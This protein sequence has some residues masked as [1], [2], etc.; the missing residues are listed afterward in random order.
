MSIASLD[1]TYCEKGVSFQLQQQKLQHQKQ[2][3]KLSAAH[4]TKVRSSF[5]PGP[6]GWQDPNE[7]FPK[8]LRL[9]KPLFVKWS[10]YMSI[11]QKAFEPPPPYPNLT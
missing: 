2:T 6:M 9:G 10:V 4:G 7:Y 3:K 11:A 5:L 1:P 8:N